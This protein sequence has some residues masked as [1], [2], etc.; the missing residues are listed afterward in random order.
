[1]ESFA[2]FASARWCPR[3]R[4]ESVP[5]CAYEKAVESLEIQLWNSRTARVS[6]SSVPFCAREE[7]FFSSKSLI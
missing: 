4:C 5:F 6:S 3:L 2:C 1:V 7:S